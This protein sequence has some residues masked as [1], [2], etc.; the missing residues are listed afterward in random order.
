[1]RHNIFIVQQQLCFKMWPFNVVIQAHSTRAVS[2]VMHNFGKK[3]AKLASGI[4]WPCYDDI[5]H[6][7]LVSELP[8][9]Q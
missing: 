3:K 9:I 7:R 2:R 5:A 8:Y 1:M 4:E 6:I